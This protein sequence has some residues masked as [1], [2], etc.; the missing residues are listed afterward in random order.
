MNTGQ[1]MLVIVAFAMLSTLALA[2]NATITTTLTVSFE[3]ELALNAHS[4]AQSLL[5]E[6]VSQDFDEKVTGGVKIYL[7][8][9]MTPTGSFGPDAGEALPGGINSFDIE[10]ITKANFH[11]QRSF[12]DVDDYQNY[13][14]RTKNLLGWVFEATVEIHYVS[15]ANPDNV[16]EP[17]TWVKRVTVSVTNPHMTKYQSGEMTGVVIPVVMRDLVIYRRYY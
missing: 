5:D 13:K 8:T 11:S 3:S 16:S 10:D 6:I 17:Q 12:D 9:N 1:M 2:I 4:I 15:E 7:E 14:R